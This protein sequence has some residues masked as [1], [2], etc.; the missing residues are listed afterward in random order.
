M[1]YTKRQWFIYRLKQSLNLLNKV[2]LYMNDVIKYVENS[3]YSKRFNKIDKKI[4]ECLIKLC[5]LLIKVDS[6]EV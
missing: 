1:T 6:K 5:E 4:D 3:K 2:S